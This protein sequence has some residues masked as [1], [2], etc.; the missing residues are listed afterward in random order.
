MHNS[1]ETIRIFGL[2]LVANTAQTMTSAQLARWIV[3]APPS[4]A[5][6]PSKQWT[7]VCL[8]CGDPRPLV[9]PGG[10]L[11]LVLGDGPSR[12][13]NL[14]ALVL[15][16]LDRLAT[17]LLRLL[18]SGAD[19]TV[20]RLEFAQRVLVVVDEAEAGGLAA[21]E[22]GAE[23][24]DYGEL[25][26]GLVHAADDLLQLRAGDVR[27]AGVD[28]VH[29]HLPPGQKGVALEL[30]RLYDDRRIAHGCGFTK[31]FPAALPLLPACQEPVG[32]VQRECCRV[33]I[34]GSVP[35]FWSI[36]HA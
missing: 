35:A 33:K 16:L 10:P 4:R 15:R 8:F 12:S 34:R 5:L 23:A 22:F 2:S 1:I 7:L 30:A 14:K 21:A 19:E 6:Q 13:P 29:N 28:D 17:L 27:S 9:G 26:V 11:R 25:R 24:E 20:L 18:K 36:R 32:G 31:I 3:T